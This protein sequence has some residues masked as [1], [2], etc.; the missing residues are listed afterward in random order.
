MKTNIITFLVLLYVLLGTTYSFL[1]TFAQTTEPAA[2]EPP[3]TEQQSI[4]DIIISL[5]DQSNS[6]VEQQIQQLE[7]QG[8][9]IP[10]DVNT[11]FEEGVAEYQTTIES[12]EN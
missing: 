3:A 1:P 6:Q 9:E 4:S 11:I 8:I 2:V 10:P 7:S 5:L 12:L